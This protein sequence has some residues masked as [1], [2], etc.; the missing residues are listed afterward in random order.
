MRIERARADILGFGQFRSRK[1]LGPELAAKRFGGSSEYTLP[2]FGLKRNVPRA[3]CGVLGVS[4]IR[5]S[6]IIAAASLRDKRAWRIT[7][8]A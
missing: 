7:T 5:S 6:I 8:N 4:Y 1:F 2:R 3:R